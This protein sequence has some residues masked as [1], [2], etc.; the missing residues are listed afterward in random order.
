MCVSTT[1]P[2]HSI[3]PLDGLSPPPLLAKLSPKA[4][5]D[6]WRFVA[7]CYRQ[8]AVSLAEDLHYSQ[9][10]YC[11]LELRL[12]RREAM[13]LA[14]EPSSVRRDLP[15]HAVSP[16]GVVEAFSDQAVSDLID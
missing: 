3:R 4:Q 12:A 6:H 5:A 13:F 10:A 9:M 16:A 8:Q 14:P 1:T 15:D 2:H 7:E 11:E